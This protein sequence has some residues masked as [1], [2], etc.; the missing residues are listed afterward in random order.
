MLKSEV[1][2]TDARVAQN[3]PADFHFHRGPDHAA[4]LCGSNLAELRSLPDAGTAPFAGVGKAFKM[5]ALPAAATVIDIGSGGS[6]DCRL[7]MRRVGPQVH[8]LRHDGREA[9]A[10]A[11]R[12]RLHLTGRK[13]PKS[14]LLGPPAR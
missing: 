12:A 1:Q 8:R 2:A 9:R 7:A 3:P 13:S 11:Q 4:R 6:M 14:G 5:D 10:G